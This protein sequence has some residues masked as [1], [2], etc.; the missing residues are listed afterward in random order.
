VAAHPRER[1]STEEE[2]E[3]QM[4]QSE[5][6]ASSISILPIHNEV[7]PNARWFLWQIAAGCESVRVGT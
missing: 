5:R 3:K 2:T 4:R 6:E 7:R 1:G